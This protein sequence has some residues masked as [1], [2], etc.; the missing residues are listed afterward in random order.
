LFMTCITCLVWFHGACLAILAISRAS[1][2]MP[3]RLSLRMSCGL[4]KGGL[5]KDG[6]LVGKSADLISLDDMK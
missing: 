1:Y 6:C 3:S 2:G 5:W 4:W